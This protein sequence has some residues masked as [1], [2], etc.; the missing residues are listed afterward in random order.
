L[1]AGRDDPPDDRNDDVGVGER[2]PPPA[3]SFVRRE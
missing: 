1:L 2:L 3:R